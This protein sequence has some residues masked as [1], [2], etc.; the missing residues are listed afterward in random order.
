[1][2][3]ENNTLRRAVAQKSK[4]TTTVQCISTSLLTQWEVGGGQVRR[5]SI[6]NIGVWFTFVMRDLP[7]QGMSWMYLSTE[8]VHGGEIDIDC[9]RCVRISQETSVFPPKNQLFRLVHQTLK[10]KLFKSTPFLESTC[11]LQ[12]RN[13]LLNAVLSCVVCGIITAHSLYSSIILPIMDS[14][15]VKINLH[16][17][18]LLPRSVMPFCSVSPLCSW[19]RCLWCSHCSLLGAKC[20]GPT[21]QAQAVMHLPTHC[22]EVIKIKTPFW[23]EHSINLT[24]L[25]V[26]SGCSGFFVVC[27]FLFSGHSGFDPFRS[28]EMAKEPIL[29]CLGETR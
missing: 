18:Y 14:Q 2:R 20:T 24:N 13:T 15:T 8:W 12:N 11:S 5:Y 7:R 28:G 23:M 29:F 19:D 21:C 3:E 17:C 9:L 22:Q 6:I 4:R 16:T 27:S 10:C 26:W 1:M 25:S